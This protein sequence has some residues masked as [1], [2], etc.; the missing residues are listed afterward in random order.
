VEKN[1]TSLG[2][3]KGHLPTSY[4]AEDG[5]ETISSWECIEGCS[6]AMLDTMAGIRKSGSFTGKRQSPKT[7]GI[8]GKFTGHPEKG[9]IANSG[10]ASRFYLQF[11]DTKAMLSWMQRLITPIGSA[12]FLDGDFLKE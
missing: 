2:K 4:A 11:E 7:K 9:L 8:F 3:F 5:L 6:S 10:F 1:R 12:C